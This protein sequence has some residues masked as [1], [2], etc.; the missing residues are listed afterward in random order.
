VN[1]FLVIQT[2]F[3][4]DVILATAVTEKLHQL[5]PNA[6]IDILVRK[7]TETLF[8]N[9][10]YIN[11]VLVLNKQKHKIGSLLKTITRVRKNRYEYII[12]LQR[13]G[14]S[15][16]T[17]FLSGANYKSGFHNN[18]FSFCYTHKYRH[19][20]SAGLYEVDRNQQL[21][22]FLTGTEPAR[23]ALYPSADDVKKILGYATQ[24][25]IC[26]AP[27]SVWF[28]KRLPEEKWIALADRYKKKVYILGSPAENVLGERIMNA[29]LNKNIQN[30]C[31]KL[32][33]LEM[34][35]LMQ[36]AHMNYMNDS[37]PLHICSAMNA[38]CTAFFLSTVPEFGF[39]PLSDDAAVIQ[40][41]LNLDC[42]P[43]GVH[44][45]QACPKGHFKCATT[46]DINEIGL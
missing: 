31:G 10:P 2:A 23:P 20:L 19:E 22:S 43:C 44:G 45:Y 33:L 46:I 15:G 30:L 3:L 6:I 4:G 17:T 38:P 35:A 13:F 14:S 34:A 26:I 12:N 16:I 36:R 11:E 37:A 41:K 9:H 42:K 25:Y 40:T 5:Y 21:I 18:P 39:G 32:S 28:T 8:N 7:G 29:S 1:K 24:E 27:G